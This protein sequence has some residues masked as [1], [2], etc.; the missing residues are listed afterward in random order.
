M[1]KMDLISKAKKTIDHYNM[2]KSKD[3]ILVA[4]SGGPDSVALLLVLLELKK[5][6]DLSLYIAH[7][8]HKLRGKESDKDQGFVRKLAFR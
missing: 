4:V 8:N 6:F 5:K 2:I 1:K 3:R 7:V